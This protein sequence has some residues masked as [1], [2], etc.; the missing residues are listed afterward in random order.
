MVTTIV[1]SNESMRTFPEA[2]V[3]VA[4]GAVPPTVWRIELSVSVCT[5]RRHDRHDVDKQNAPAEGSEVEGQ[6]H[7]ET[8]THTRAAAA[9]DH[10]NQLDSESLDRIKCG[11][12]CKWR[13]RN[14]HRHQSAAQCAHCIQ[15]WTQRIPLCYSWH[16]KFKSYK[17]CNIWTSRKSLFVLQVLYLHRYKT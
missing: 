11:K 9:G 10:N 2:G 13:G 4:R 14:E 7:R 15:M 16:G 8:H 1:R 12:R 17:N 3:E 5:A 6:H